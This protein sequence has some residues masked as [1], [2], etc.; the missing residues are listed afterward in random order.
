MSCCN[1]IVRE[2]TDIIPTHSIK[3]V[4]G[5]KKVIQILAKKTRHKKFE[6]A[7]II[8]KHLAYILN[9]IALRVSSVYP[10]VQP[11]DEEAK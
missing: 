5:S 6:N 10:S 1:L 9:G 2:Q 8:Q 11:S 4:R 3:I 7:D